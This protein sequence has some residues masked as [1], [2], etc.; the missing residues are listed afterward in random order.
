MK[1]KIL[2]IIAFPCISVLTFSAM[3]SCDVRKT[4]E[5]KMPKV[6]V[7]EKGQMPKYDVDA[8]E[9]DVTTEKKEVQVP[10][11]TT[12]TKEIEVPKVT[13]TPPEND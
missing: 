7:T 10:K 11:V 3:S 6:E 4:Q 9:V 2:K 1:T 13:I 8:P 5:G 12:E